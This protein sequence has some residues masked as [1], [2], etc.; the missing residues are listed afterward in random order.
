MP[1]TPRI[2]GR[3]QARDEAVASA[4]REYIELVAAAT[5]TRRI[6]F[7]TPSDKWDWLNSSKDPAKRRAD[8]GEHRPGLLTGAM[9]PK[10]A[11]QAVQAGLRNICLN[12]ARR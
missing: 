6:I 11:Y 10:P 7:W 2:A 12:E 4:Y 8:G 3:A 1:T 5:G 9:Q